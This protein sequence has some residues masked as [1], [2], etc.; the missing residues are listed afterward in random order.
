MYDANPPDSP[1]DLQEY[2]RST[3][4]QLRRNERKINE[5][6]ASLEKARETAKYTT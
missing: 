6:T 3:K 2:R 1:R 4:Q 5:M